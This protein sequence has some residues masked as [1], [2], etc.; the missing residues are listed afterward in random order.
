MT[1][2]GLSNLG[3]ETVECTVGVYLAESASASVVECY[4]LAS[5]SE[6]ARY[7]QVV[8]LVSAVSCSPDHDMR[9]YGT[10]GHLLEALEVEQATV[11]VAN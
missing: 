5:R 3:L 7:F 2:P 10:F 6:E 8:P 1:H 4:R 9:T 11:A